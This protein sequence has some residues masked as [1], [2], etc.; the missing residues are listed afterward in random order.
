MGARAH[1]PTPGIRLMSRSRR[2]VV[3]RRRREIIGGGAAL[4]LALGSALAV[5][6][7]TGTDLAGAASARAHNLVDLLEQRSPGVRTEDQLT[8]TKAR[9]AMLAEHAPAPVEAAVTENLA[10][11]LAPP[12]PSYLPVVQ[13]DT[14]PEL[15]FMPMPGGV[16]LSPGGGGGGGG[17]GSPDGGTPGGGGGGP[18]PPPNTPTIPVPAVPEPGTWMTMLVGFGILGWALRRGK[19]SLARE[20]L[21]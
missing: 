18:L 12:P 7:F 11:V 5:A 17:G 16:F 3:Q 9:H 13:A 10:E 21:R 14:P 2:R 15:S 1:G 20:T 8:K 6:S 4:A 19:P